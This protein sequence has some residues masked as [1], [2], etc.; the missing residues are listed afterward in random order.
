MCHIVKKRERAIR[1]YFDSL[2]KIFALMWH[3]N[4]VGKPGSKQH[5]Y[6]GFFFTS[7]AGGGGMW[8][9]AEQLDPVL[10]HHWYMSKYTESNLNYTLYN[11]RSQVKVYTL[12]FNLRSQNFSHENMLEEMINKV[13]SHFP[14]AESIIGSIQYDMLLVSTKED[15]PSYYLWRANSNHRT[16]PTEE[17]LLKKDH[18]QLYLFG[19][20]AMEANLA[21]LNIQ[22]QSSDVVI[23]ELLTIVFTFSSA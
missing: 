11:N 16:L 19:Q 12:R 7:L 23:Q 1:L 2:Q 13:F 21:E 6:F 18:N 3:I 9:P 10:K 17:T 5:F 20:K 4:M 14:K 8:I 15:V 22:F